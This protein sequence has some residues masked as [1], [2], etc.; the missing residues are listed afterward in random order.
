MVLAEKE[1]GHR[2]QLVSSRQS[3]KEIKMSKELITMR[4][5]FPDHQISKLPKGTKAQNECSYDQKRSCKVCG[6]FHHPEVKHLD[7]VG[8]AALTD[9]MLDVD[10]NWSWE[11]MA[12]VDGLPAFDATGGLWIRLTINGV[13]RIGYGHAEGKTHMDVGAREK[14]VIGDALRN[15]AMR[16]GAA[17]DLWFKGDLHPEEPDQ[18]KPEPAKQ[19]YPDP[20]VPSG[21]KDGLNPDDVPCDEF[22]PQN[23]E[24][25]N[26]PSTKQQWGEIKT[27]R[28]RALKD[29]TFA[30]N[31]IKTAFGKSKYDE[32]TQ[33]EAMETIDYFNGIAEMIAANDTPSKPLGDDNPL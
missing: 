25:E 31:Y 3:A 12:L 26:I 14:E 28:E 8:H 21:Q 2:D 32:L 6:G 10:P 4:T 16:F 15:A 13:T 30:M 17:L 7:Y 20:V 19:K 23:D 9:R 24:L 27:A 18:K 29:S 11:P 5:P 1:S 22:I 33:F